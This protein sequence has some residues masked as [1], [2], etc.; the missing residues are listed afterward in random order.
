L[1]NGNLE[2]GKLGHG[3]RDL[4]EEDRAETGVKGTNTLF[5]EDTSE[6]ASETV[7]ERGLRDETDTGSLKGTESNVGKEL[8]DTGC[9]EVDGLTVLA[10]GFNTEE[11]DSLLLPEFVT[12]RSAK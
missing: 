9:S 3:V 11:V 8:G 6:T 2:N 4:L 7:G 12:V 5:T 10:G 1:L